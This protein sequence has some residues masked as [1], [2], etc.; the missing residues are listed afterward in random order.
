[1]ASRS[2]RRWF[3]R[4]FEQ[5]SGASL[6]VRVWALRGGRAGERRPGVP[7]CAGMAAVDGGCD[8]AI[9]ALSKQQP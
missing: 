1:M 4:R 2:P 6:I 3:Q 9:G 7:V 5:L 8:P